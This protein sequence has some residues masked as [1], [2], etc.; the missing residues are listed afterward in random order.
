MR[1]IKKLMEVYRENFI[2][3]SNSAIN[4]ILH[5]ISFE[6]NVLEMAQINSN[7]LLETFS[8]VLYGSFTNIAG[9][10]INFLDNLL[11]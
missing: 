7:T 6:N 1:V 10:G 9:D 8:D 5:S 3:F 2:L 4:I 11:P